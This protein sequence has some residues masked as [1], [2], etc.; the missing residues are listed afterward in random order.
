MDIFISTLLLLLI[1][2]LIVFNLVDSYS[3]LLLIVSVFS[4]LRMHNVELKLLKLAITKTKYE[5]NR[6]DIL[7]CIGMRHAKL[8]EFNRAT[9]YFLE[10]FTRNKNDFFFKKEYKIMLQSFVETNKIEEGKI[11]Y[12]L[13]L[14]KAEKEMKYKIITN[15]F[16]KYFN[17]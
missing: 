2:Y 5:K 17:K 16:E 9:K 8:K 4:F 13:F 10:A 6:C 7:Y 11:I 14:E 15:T 3:R 12:D 1:L